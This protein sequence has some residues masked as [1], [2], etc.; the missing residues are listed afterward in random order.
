MAGHSI[1]ANGYSAQI[2]STGAGLRAVRWGDRLLTETWEIEP[3]V[4]PPLSCGLVLAPWPNRTGDGRYTYDGQSYQLPITEAARNNANHGFVRMVDWNV[5]DTT[6]SSVTLG[7][8]V[9]QHPGWPFDLQLTVTYSLDAGG[10]TVTHTTTNNGKQRAP[11]ALGQHTFVR[12]GDVPADDCR[13]QLA[14]RKFQ[15]LDPERQLPAGPPVDVAGTDFDFSTPQPVSG[16]WLDTPFTDMADEAGF[17]THRLI[18]PDGDATELWTDLNFPWVQAFTADP[19]HDQP[20]PG[21]GRAVA[22]EP[23]TAP[24]NAL[25]SGIDLI[26]LEPGQIWTGRWGLRYRGAGGQTP[27]TGN[28]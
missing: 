12:L 26:D 3:G 11:Y 20:Y 22:I 28:D 2:A 24:P 19:A 10:L 6:G 4:K 18:G 8:A 25:A 27:M 7:I 1:E 16:H 21:R 13:L 17:I 15:P 5:L 14:A 23:M 9:G